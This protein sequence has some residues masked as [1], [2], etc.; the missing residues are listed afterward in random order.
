MEKEDEPTNM[1]NKTAQEILTA[2]HEGRIPNDSEV[3]VKL[4]SLAERAP[5]ETIAFVRALPSVH[6]KIASA[7]N[8]G[9]YTASGVMAELAV[10]NKQIKP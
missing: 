3:I 7:R 2:I 9:K 5:V 8:A 6:P 4:T 10:K 1:Y